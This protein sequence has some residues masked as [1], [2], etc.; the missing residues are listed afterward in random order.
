MEWDHESAYVAL[1]ARH[2]N[3]VG[4][5]KQ[6]TINPYVTLYPQKDNCAILYSP[7]AKYR[8]RPVHMNPDRREWNPDVLRKLKRAIKFIRKSTNLQDGQNFDFYEVVDWGEFASALNL[9]RRARPRQP[10]R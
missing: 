3:R 1:K 4:K 2:G 6:S 9:K 10:G 5:L 7:D 8:R